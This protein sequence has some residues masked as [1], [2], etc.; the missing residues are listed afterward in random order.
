MQICSSVFITISHYV[1]C[2][3]HIIGYFKIYVLIF[4]EIHFRTSSVILYQIVRDITYWCI[5]NGCL[6][7]LFFFIIV[8]LLWWDILHN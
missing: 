4:G 5:C 7:Q 3:K 1:I 8:I 6:V 2:G